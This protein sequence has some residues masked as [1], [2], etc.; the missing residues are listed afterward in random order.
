[1]PQLLKHN[2]LSQSRSRSRR[3]QEAKLP[4]ICEK[5]EILLWLIFKSLIDFNLSHC[6]ESLLGR[7]AFSN[8][9]SY[10]ISELERNIACWDIMR[11]D[12][13]FLEVY[14]FFQHCVSVD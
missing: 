2:R 9:I 14:Y 12:Q 10:E 5:K 8:P 7:K 13:Y 11:R 4:S 3:P 6:V 1:M